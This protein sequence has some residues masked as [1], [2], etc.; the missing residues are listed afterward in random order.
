MLLAA[1]ITCIRHLVFAQNNKQKKCSTKREKK[2]QIFQESRHDILYSCTYTHFWVDIIAW[3]PRKLLPLCVYF[4][5][6]NTMSMRF[7]YFERQN[8]SSWPCATL[9]RSVSLRGSRYA[10]SHFDLRSQ[11]PSHSSFNSHTRTHTETPETLCWIF[12]LQ[13]TALLSQRGVIID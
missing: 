5:C 3:H 2:R 1:A 8:V 13:I 11:K 4:I 9:S 12:A 7:N 10:K 6:T